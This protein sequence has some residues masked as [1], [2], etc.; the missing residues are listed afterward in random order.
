MTIGEI[1]CRKVDL[2]ELFESVQTAAQRMAAGKVSTLVVVDDDRVPIGLI[3]DRDL[4]VRV[5]A[6]GKD[7]KQTNVHDV[8]TRHVQAITEDRSVE[9]AMEV[10]RGGPFRQLVVVDEDGRLVGVAD[11]DHILEVLAAEFSSIGKLIHAKNKE[12]LAADG[13]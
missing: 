9:T 2:A 8:M 7:P 12:S 5:L 6:N 4:T 1:C 13:A 10:M 11:I 3:T